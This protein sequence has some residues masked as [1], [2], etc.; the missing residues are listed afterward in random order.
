M[1]SGFTPP[2]NRF[3][4]YTKKVEDNTEVPYGNRKKT[5]N[6]IS[7]FVV[8]SIPNFVSFIVKSKDYDKRIIDDKKTIN[9]VVLFSEKD[10]VPGMFKALATHFRDQIDFYFVNSEKLS[11]RVKKMKISEFP[12]ILVYHDYDEFGEK[13]EQSEVVTYKGNNEIQDLI[14]FL[15][16]FALAEKLSGKKQFGG[17][18]P[19][20]QRRGRYTFVTH[21]NYTKGIMEDYR[22]QVIFF[23][24]QFG[25]VQTVFEEVAEAIHGPANVVY[26]NC[27]HE[28]SENVAKDKFGVK[29]F[30]RVIVFSTNS[31]KTPENALEISSVVES[32]DI[33]NIVTN[34]EIKDNIREVSDSSISSIF[35]NNA[36][37]LRKVTLIY[38]YQ[39]ESDGV[40]L[41]FKSISSNPIFRENFDFIALKSP[42]PQTVQQ[43]QIPKLPTIIGGIPP[44]PGVDATTPEGQGMVQTMI[45][46]GS[47]E[48]YFELLEYQLGVLR[49][50]FPQEESGEGDKR[51]AEATVEFQE[52]SKA[53]FEEI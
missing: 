11:K 50:V 38:L 20:N 36:L 41:A 16:P 43:F 31:E 26:F 22:T 8:S 15:A 39:D 7:K 30:P 2:A 46:Q 37:Q 49:A 13:L 44:P 18:K 42:S 47:L 27:S 28:E 33:I 48:D 3:N 4:P 1:I 25:E 29:K 45:Y 19:I 52:V 14:K 21:K 24:K 53:N 23:S 40:P 9:K 17:D 6:A 10:K 34:T 12:A 5:E 35:L 32:E 51:G